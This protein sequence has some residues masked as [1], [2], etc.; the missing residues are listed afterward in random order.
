[1]QEPKFFFWLE[2]LQMG[3][4]RTGSIGSVG[5]P[6]FDANNQH[7]KIGGQ[8]DLPDVARALMHQVPYEDL[9]VYHRFRGGNR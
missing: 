5:E 4:S 2:A 9:N 7:C 3:T 6:Y 1:M 8:N